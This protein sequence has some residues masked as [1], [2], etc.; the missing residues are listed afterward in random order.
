MYHIFFIHSSVK[1]N[2][3]SFQLLASQVTADA[4]EDVEKEEYCSIAG[5]IASFYNH[6]GNQS[7]GSSENCT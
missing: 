7:G 2:L 5:G 4:G 6:S 3:G 1:G